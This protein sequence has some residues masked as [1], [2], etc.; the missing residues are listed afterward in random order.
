LQPA[1][2]NIFTP[3]S[4][5]LPEGI[6]VYS[7]SLGAQEETYF[8]QIH[9]AG[10]NRN[11]KLPK[12]TAFALK[13]ALRIFWGDRSPCPLLLKADIPVPPKN[14]KSTYPLQNPW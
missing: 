13:H 7:Y 6:D 9:F 1:G 4:G 8:F 2:V 14:K 12:L 3:F 5:S 11:N 10:L